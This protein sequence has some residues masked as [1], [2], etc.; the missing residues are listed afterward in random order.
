MKAFPFLLSLFLFSFATHAEKPINIV[1]INSPV[2]ETY[3]KFKVDTKN[4]FQ[5]RDVEF[6][7]FMQSEKTDSTSVKGK[8]EKNNGSYIASVKTSEFKPG[9]YKIDVKLL[10]GRAILSKQTIIQGS[11]EIDSS[12]EVPDPGEAGKSTLEGIDT[13]KDGIRDD[14]QR[15][16][17]ENY[18]STVFPSTNK[19]LKQAF[20]YAQLTLL[21]NQDKIKNNLYSGK[22]TQAYM[23]LK[24]IRG[25][26]YA[27]AIFEKYQ[28]LIHNTSHRIKAHL[29]S[30]ANLHGTTLEDLPANILKIIPE[31]CEEQN[32]QKEQ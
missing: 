6:I 25:D 26:Y 21:N 15:W 32:P 23:C 27:D 7:F 29:T 12:L 28:S 2:K 3:A 18:N 1:A 31:H 30:E 16:A 4:Q 14:L 9:T 20:K 5:P 10:S 17:N 11:F 13:D 24:W 8:I 19:A 22:A